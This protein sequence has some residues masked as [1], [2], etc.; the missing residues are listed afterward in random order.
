MV[1]RW[2]LYLAALL[3][4]LVFYWSYRQWTA[5]VIL[6]AVAGLPVLS[7]VLSLPAMVKTRLEISVPAR[8]SVDADAVLEVD[9]GG[10]RILPP[11][12]IK[13]RQN[14]AL[15][16]LRG[17]CR[18]GQPLLSEHCGLLQIQVKYARVYDYMG[19]FFLSRNVKKE[20][21]LSILPLSVMPAQIPDTSRKTGIRLQPRRGG[22][23]AENH[24]LRLYRPGD[25][26]QQIHWKMT[27]KTGKLILREPLEPKHSPMVLRLDLTGSPAEL[28]KKLG[29]LLFLSRYLLHRGFPHTVQA[30]TKKGLVQFPVSD[31][32][33]LLAA[34]E[35]FFSCGKA[36]ADRVLSF[37]A[38]GVW[39]H[40]IGGESD[41]KA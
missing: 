6:V 13:A 29:K 24:D 20:H 3:G 7:L 41:E 5:Y 4:C 10:P 40:Y 22:G 1:K 16:G 18:P 38:G 28:D 36:E 27:A 17:P 39:W 30:W 2:L 14:H 12:R 34:M 15:S 19:L 23:F 26:L 32:D 25:S 9:A 37:P 11:W 31:E 35:Q 33:T 8:I 21:T